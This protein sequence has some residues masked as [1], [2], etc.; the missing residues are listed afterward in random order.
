[1]NV[2]TA[3][4]KAQNRTVQIDGADKE[5]DVKIEYTHVFP[6]GFFEKYRCTENIAEIAHDA[7]YEIAILENA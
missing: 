2:E 3:Q 1:M 6:P 4:Y 7:Y 5:G